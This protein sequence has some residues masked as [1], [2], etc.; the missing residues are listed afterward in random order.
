M[1]TTLTDHQTALLKRAQA[2]T[3]GQ[4]RQQFLTEVERHSLS[5]LVARGLMKDVVGTTFMLT[6][7]GRRY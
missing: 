3:F 6:D 5:G 7:A 4:L 1:T 2:A